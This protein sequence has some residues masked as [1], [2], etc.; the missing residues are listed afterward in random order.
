MQKMHLWYLLSAQDLTENLIVYHY[1]IFTEL[2]MNIFYSKGLRGPGFTSPQ[3]SYLH[4]SIMYSFVK[5]NPTHFLQNQPL[6]ILSE[7][8][9]V[10]LGVFWVTILHGLY[11]AVVVCGDFF[12]CAMMKNLEAK[13]EYYI[14]MQNMG[15]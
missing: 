7:S 2:L 6:A 9:L 11:N 4:H 3:T 10:F 13:I 15:F 5:L 12:A 14:H 8:W 1:E